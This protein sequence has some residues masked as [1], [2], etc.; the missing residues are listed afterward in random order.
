MKRIKLILCVVICL[1]LIQVVSAQKTNIEPGL[2]DVPECPEPNESERSAMI[3]QLYLTIPNRA[4][5]RNLTGASSETVDMIRPVTDV[6]VC[7][8]LTE[9]VKD[10]YNGRF[11]TEKYKKLYYYRTDNFYYILWWYKPEYDGDYYTSRK[12]LFIVV[13]KDFS[14]INKFVY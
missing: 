9:I 14:Q 1:A 4:A 7:G 13:S 2:I 11:P 8:Q 5:D 12:R 6:N 3:V 10:L